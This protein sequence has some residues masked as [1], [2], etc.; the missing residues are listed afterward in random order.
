M[1]FEDGTF[2]LYNQ[3]L[4]RIDATVSD[5]RQEMV[6]SL[7]SVMSITSAALH[8]Q[9]IPAVL[10]TILYLFN[11]SLLLKYVAPY[12]NAHGLKTERDARIIAIYNRPTVQLLGTVTFNELRFETPTICILRL[13]SSD[14]VELNV[15]V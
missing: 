11:V 5:L 13:I 9:M 7:S 6:K 10:L 14:S 12:N 3:F 1:V 8:L 4:K 15:P 2:L